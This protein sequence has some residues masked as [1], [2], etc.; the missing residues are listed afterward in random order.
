MKSV[1]LS[2]AVVGA[3]A[4]C[5]NLAE[6]QGPL[7]LEGKIPLGDVR[8]RIDHMAID[9]ARRHLFVA[10]LENDSVAVVDIDG[11]KV[12]HVITDVKGPQ[13]LGYLASTNTLFVA[14][15]GDGSLRMFQGAEYRAV[16]RIHLGDDADNV[17]VDAEANQVLVSY[18]NGALAVIN[19]TTRSKIADIAL[20]G[21]PQGF[22]LDRRTSRIY[23]NDPA[24]QA[25]VVVDRDAGKPTAIWRTGNDTNFPMAIDE[26]SNRVLVAFRNPAS[27]VVFAALNGA[28][29]SSMEACADADDM[30][31]DARRRRV[32]VSCGDG[33]LDVFDTAG[34]TYRRLAR[35]ATIAGAR[36]SLYVPEIDRLFVAARA[37]SEQSAAIWVFRPEP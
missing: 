21:H 24:G 9:L 11:R 13:G 19:A 10:E 22:Q 34:T 5:G 26:E 20:T 27:L 32:Y 35:I 17:Q 14:N 7:V 3:F 18:G 15:G 30:F 33:F 36:T 25:V 29:V 37:T 4:A 2:L 28:I 12:V 6:A 8:G 1:L 23:V 16:E 31:V